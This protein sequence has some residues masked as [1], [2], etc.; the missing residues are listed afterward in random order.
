MTQAK[1][2]TLQQIEPWSR[3]YSS[4]HYMESLGKFGLQTTANVQAFMNSLT[5]KIIQKQIVEL[6]LVVESLEKQHAEELMINA[7]RHLLLSILLMVAANEDSAELQDYLR[8]LEDAVQKRL[9]IN[10]PSITVESKQQFVIPLFEL[11][12]RIETT[13]LDEKQIELDALVTALNNL[14]QELALLDYATDDFKATQAEI[15]RELH[16]FEEV[17]NGLER[18]PETVRRLQN[19]LNIKLQGMATSPRSQVPTLKPNHQL[20]EA[21]LK[22][23]LEALMGETGSMP[24]PRPAPTALIHKL[25]NEQEQALTAHKRRL[26][27][28]REQK[29][30]DV[31]AIQGNMSHLKNTYIQS[32]NDSLPKN[33]HEFDQNTINGLFMHGL[34]QTPRPTFADQDFQETLFERRRKSR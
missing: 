23:L 26:T 9:K 11:A 31:V 10:Q 3:A 2:L 15:H 28:Q 1:T 21:H 25:I 16:S 4:K 6:F 22:I 18:Q 29:R 7:F 19:E 27:Q 17:M 30:Q 33:R 32:L 14:D 12:R 5:G 20:R 8:L 34:F 13:I 24:T